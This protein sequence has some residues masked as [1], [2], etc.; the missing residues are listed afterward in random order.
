MS[1]YYYDNRNEL[2]GAVRGLA[3]KK[4]N[5]SETDRIEFGEYT[6]D[7]GY[8]ET[9]SYTEYEFVVILNGDVVYDSKKGTDYFT[10]PFEGFQN[11]L[12]GEE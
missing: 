2:V 12:T 7:S 10:S 6:W 11:W 9:C 3:A 4:L 5:A 8:C 1:I